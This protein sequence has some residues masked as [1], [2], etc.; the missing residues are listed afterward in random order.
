MSYFVYI[1]ECSDTTYYT[2]S[3]SDLEKRLH[4][5]NHTKSG[6]H[7]TK[8]RRPVKLIHF[9]ELK[10]LRDARKRE[11]EL[12]GMTRKQKDELISSKQTL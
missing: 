6:A 12:K 2:G 4:E 1:V 10:S 5:H 8:L 9:E 7:Y 11:Y 3:T